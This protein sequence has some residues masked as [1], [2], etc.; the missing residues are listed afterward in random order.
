MLRVYQS[1][2]ANTEV[3]P[4]VVGKGTC[5]GIF[6]P[7]EPRG[8]PGK[9]V[10]GLPRTYLPRH[11][12]GPRP[13]GHARCLSGCPRWPANTS[14]ASPAAPRHRRSSPPS[15]AP[16]CGPRGSGVL[17]LCLHLQVAPGWWL[18]GHMPAP[19]LQR[20]LVKQVLRLLP[21]KRGVPPTQGGYSQCWASENMTSVSGCKAL[22]GL[23]GEGWRGSQ[24]LSVCV[25]GGSRQRGTLV[26]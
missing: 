2:V 8:G 26:N 11:Q 19:Q 21:C 25:L 4:V 24:P 17:P 9:L 22:W 12:T 18:S 3:V 23:G 14:T 5:V 1:V 16:T 15:P 20:R 13:P 7:R 6:D 10:C